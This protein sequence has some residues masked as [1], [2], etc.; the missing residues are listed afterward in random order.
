M[1]CS[2]LLLST[3]LD[4]ELNDRRVAE[5]DA[6]L[7]A[8]ERCQAGLS[9]LR[10]E[11]QR[12]SALARVRVS[13]ESTRRLLGH[14]GLAP[15]T[16]DVSLT[17]DV[18]PNERERP[19]TTPWFEPR[20]GK[21]LPWSPGPR[22]VPQPPPL[23]G[24]RTPALASAPVATIDR[25]G[26]PSPPMVGRHFDAPSPEAA[27]LEVP[28]IAVNA[29]AHPRQASLEAVVED[30]PPTLGVSAPTAPPAGPPH[31]VPSSGVADPLRR[32]RDAVA[33]R[34]ALMRSAPRDPDSLAITTTSGEA[35]GDRVFAE[36]RPDDARL[37]HVD[38]PQPMDSVRGDESRHVASVAAGSADWEMSDDFELQTD[39]V[40][41]RPTADGEHAPGRHVRGISQ[42]RAGVADSLLGPARAPVR[43][44]RFVRA[45]PAAGTGDRRLW[46]FAAVTAL[47]MV[48]GLLVGK[49]VQVRPLD[50]QSH[51]PVPPIHTEAPRTS[52]APTSAPAAAPATAPSPEQLTGAQ[53]IGSGAAGYAVGGLRYGDH[54]GDF[55]IVI[56]L[57][58][59]SVGTPAG[60][61]TATAGFGNPTT[62]YLILADVVPAAAATPPPGSL[63]TGVSL[64]P[65]SPIAGHV[66][67]QISLTRA[68]RLSMLYLA[69]PTRLV[70][71][72]R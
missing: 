46:A 26:S 14:L 41:S 22:Q 45:L 36:P 19:Q 15:S 54:P 53:T 65:H 71:D 66:V 24:S 11:S 39:A 48:V 17:A 51:V 33:L 5:L 58:P 59:V 72:L 23:P 7:I 29:P 8:C 10:E 21:A 4:G 63:V 1:R 62:L 60:S 70:I 32:L 68:V 37:A 64:L 20:P 2:L 43:L 56:D 47:L 50:A 13:E 69:G 25:P 18:Q 52:I 31:R 3:Y 57:A 49:S 55:R 12:I 67:Y 9:Y 28:G 30:P 40:P 6:H 44:P 35:T 61:P 16:E 34:W 27:Q 38:P 42:R